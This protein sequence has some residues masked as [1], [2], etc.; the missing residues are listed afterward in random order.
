MFAHAFVYALAASIRFTKQEYAIIILL[1][2][3]INV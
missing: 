1:I 3:R 2:N